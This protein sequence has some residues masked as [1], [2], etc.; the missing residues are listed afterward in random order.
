MDSMLSIMLKELDQW[1]VTKNRRITLHV[2]GGYALELK[3]IQRGFQTEDIDS[4]L[5]ITENDIIEKIH[6]IGEI[7]GNPNWFDFGAASLI[8]P[9]GYQD[10]L[11]KIEGHNNIDL[12]TLSNIDIIKMKVA[13]YHSRRERGIYRDLEDLQKLS[14]TKVQ[15][16]DAIDFYFREYSKDLSGKFKAEFKTQVEELKIELLRICK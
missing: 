4:V 5:A 14:P 1:L 7:N 15:I 2:I 16:E 12:Y 8:V 10:R 6:S 11:D 9:S 3:N 13:A